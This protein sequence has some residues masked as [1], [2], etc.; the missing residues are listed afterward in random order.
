MRLLVYIVFGVVISGIGYHLY[1][2]EVSRIKA[3]ADLNSAKDE[4]NRLEAETA[5]LTDDIE[6]YSDPHNLEK[7]L[8][9]Q[10][11]YRAPDEKL[12]IVVPEDN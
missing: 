1:G 3:I 4:L 7:V 2:A 9:A 6:Y 11:N 12:I 5:K 8:R 10:F